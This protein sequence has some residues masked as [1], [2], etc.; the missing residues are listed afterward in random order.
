M[1]ADTI[2]DA[3]DLDGARGADVEAARDALAAMLVQRELLAEALRDLG[4]DDYVTDV[5]EGR[6]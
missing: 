4:Q 3:L 2:S 1:S 5:L 6:V